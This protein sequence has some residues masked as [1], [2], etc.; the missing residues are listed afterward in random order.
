MVSIYEDGK[1]KYSVEM[2][3]GNMHGYGIEYKY[4]ENNK[5]VKV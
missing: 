5:R 4:D 1:L 2:K 3:N